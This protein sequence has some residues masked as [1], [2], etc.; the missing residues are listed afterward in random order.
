V[1]T[2]RGGRGSEAAHRRR[3]SAVAGQFRSPPN[4][5]CRP[6]GHLPIRIPSFHHPRSP[7]AR[8]HRPCVRPARPAEGRLRHP[9]IAPLRHPTAPSF[10]SPPIVH[11]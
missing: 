2:R 11:Q 9:F 4:A 3:P 1:A 8:Q 7:P 5:P 10:A 6:P